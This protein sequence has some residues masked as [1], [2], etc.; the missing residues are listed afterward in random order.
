MAN[1]KSSA[2]RAKQSLVRQK[3]NR[4]WMKQA[5]TYEAALDKLLQ[6]SKDSKAIGEALKAFASKVDRAASK[7]ALSKQ[8]ASRRVAAMSKKA[9]AVTQAG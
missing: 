4:S 8:R 1:H 7:G 2:K 9:H 6:T 5:K 3:R